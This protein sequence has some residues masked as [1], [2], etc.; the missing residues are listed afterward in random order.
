MDN[1]K[2]VAEVAELFN[3]SGYKVDTS[4]KI[5]F[6][7]I[8]IRAEE[9]QGLI[10]KIVLIECADYNKPVGIDKLQEDIRKL[11]SAK[12]ALKDN[13]IIMHVSRKGYSANAKGYAFENGIPIYSI[14]SLANQLINFNDYIDAIENEQIRDV[15]LKE[16]QPNPLYIEEK[17][18]T[19]HSSIHFLKT[20]L[21]SEKRWLTLLGDYGVGKS[22]TLK[23]LLYELIEDYKSNPDITPLPL[24]I[25][26]QQFT[27]AFD[28][29]NL[30]L[31]TFQIYGI[32]GIH[33]S[34][35]EYL[36][37]NG[38][39]VFLLDS[40]DEMAQHLNRNVIRN[41]LKEILVGISQKSK[42]IMT[43]RPN[44]FEGRAERLLLV[45]KNGSLE[46]H[47]LDRDDYKFQASL[48]RE[49]RQ[50]LSLTQF[51]RLCDLSPDQRKKL[52][53]IVLGKG[54]ESYKK[55][56]SLFERFQNLEYISQRA[57]IARLLTSVATTISES[58]EITTIDGYPLIPDDLKDLNE[59]KIFEIII[60]N[61]LYRDKNIGVISTANRL[62]FLRTF[63][64]F[65]Q[66]PNRSSFAT[67][68][69]L[70]SIVSKLF[71]KEI[72]SSDTPEQ[73]LEEYY[74][75]CRR[76]SGLTTENQFYDNSGKIDSPI[77][78]E[79]IDSNVGFSHNSLREYLIADAIVDYLKNNKVYPGLN[80]IFITEVIASF[81][82]KIDHYSPDISVLL[83]KYYKNE[84]DSKLTEILFKLILGFINDDNNFVSLLGNPPLFKYLDLSVTDL[85]SLPLSNS[86]FEQCIL[87]DTDL[88]NSD[89][90]KSTFNGSIIEN[91]MFDDSFLNGA[92]FTKAEINSIYVYDEY[93]THTTSILKGKNAR[94]WL[95]SRGAKVHP[96]NDLNPI[97]GQPWYE[98]AREVAKTIVKR[99]SGTH[100]DVSL[101]K[102]T[103]DN[104][105]E[106]A[107]EFAD[108]LISHKILN[109]VSK[110]NT[111][112]GYVVKLD[113]KYRK[114]ITEFSEEGKIAPEIKRFIDKHIGK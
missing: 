66:K 109:K 99:I 96:S 47:E 74:R 30:I 54:S 15:I 7:E 28:F 41:N 46:W 52:F 62:L 59:S 20:W 27:K 76:H 56:L 106:F 25:P 43:S 101:A 37:N 87:A 93:D 111:G 45:D 67:P 18:T 92:D 71:S 82:R 11:H 60:Y 19:K 95:Y 12:E 39:I 105:R 72:K 108:Y 110:S 63:A 90:R 55:L 75:T 51:A 89:L 57:V 3:V 61:L 48:S 44:Y 21:Q 79:D 68:S 112:P 83:S 34:A 77:D 70:K 58:K 13:A 31:R 33:Y 65:L 80:S 81:V 53:E 17:R 73:Q 10:R 32:S 85:S 104:Q 42:A 4:V 5:N 49:I 1:T 24:F 97:L 8:D 14:E 22:W 107:K 9:L 2:L 103:K 100:Q 94:Q 69:E 26:L 36:M 64:I 78:D 113:K 88:R 38:R 84:T 114:M 35:F 16:Y 23:K 91:V 86:L 102:G 98:A 40:F 50:E 6:R 29:E